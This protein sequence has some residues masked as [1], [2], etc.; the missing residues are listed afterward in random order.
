MR[1]HFGSNHR[2]VPLSDAKCNLD[3]GV[4]LP[5]KYSSDY[6]YKRDF[7]FKNPNF[8]DDI[9]FDQRDDY[10]MM[11]DCFPKVEILDACKAREKT[12]IICG[13][14]VEHFL[15]G[16]MLSS[17]L[18]E[19]MT[20]GGLASKCAMGIRTGY[21]GWDELYRFL[22]E[23]CENSDATRFD[24]SISPKLLKYVYLCRE[25]LTVFTGNQRNMFWWYFNNLVRRRS[26]LSHGSVFNVFGGNG[27]GQYNTS[28]DNTIAHLLCLAYAHVRMGNKYQDF[29]ECKQVVYGDDYIGQAMPSIFWK[30][31]VETGIC[32]KKTPVM[33]KDSCDF[34]SSTFASTPYGIA[35]SPKTDK[36]LFSVFTCENRKW[37]SFKQEKLY[38]LWLNYYFTSYRHVFE[39]IMEDCGL[40]FNSFDA[41]DFHFG[42]M[43]GF[44]EHIVKMLPQ[45]KV[46]ITAKSVSVNKR[47]RT[48]RNKKNRQKR[49][50]ALQSLMA[51]PGAPAT[52]AATLESPLDSGKLTAVDTPRTRQQLTKLVA[53]SC[54][55]CDPNAVAWY[56]KYLDP[57]GS[58]ESGRVIG[59]CGKIPDGLVKFSVDAE[60]RVI[61]DERVPEADPSA[62]A[63]SGALWSL[64]IFSFPMYRTAY[65][66][67]CNNQNKEF[68]TDDDLA[69]CVALNSLPDWRVVVDNGQWVPFGS[70]GSGWFFRIRQL[71]PTYDLPDPT[72]GDVRTVTDYRITYKSLSCRFNAPDL[73]DQGWWIGGHYALS[74]SQIQAETLDGTDL[75]SGLSMML[76]ST[77]G[78]NSIWSVQWPRLSNALQGALSGTVSGVGSNGAFLTGTLNEGSIHIN[79]PDYAGSDPFAEAGST[80]TISGPVTS[81]STVVI[82][83]TSGPGMGNTYTIP[84]TG[85]AVP[86]SIVRPPTITEDGR[87]TTTALNVNRIDM[88]PTTSAQI[89]ANNPEIENFM[90]RYSGGA[91][92]VHSK[93]RNPVFELT[94]ANQFG[95]VH[96]MTPGYAPE[97]QDSAP[98]GIRDSIDNNLSSAVAVFRSISTSASMQVI[99]YQG[100]E[101]VTA[102]NTPFGQFGHVGLQKHPPIL[103]MADDLAVRLT[104]VYEEEDNTAAVVAACAANALGNLMHSEATQSAIQAIGNGAV[105]AVTNGLGNVVSKLPSV[106]ARIPSVFSRLGARLRSRRNR[107]Q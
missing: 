37:R 87:L 93:M 50:G 55:D 57:V 36:G 17:S 77:G 91:Y 101:G 18:N 85:T 46:N 1:V 72:E 44:K 33:Y 70:E 15:V 6:V 80:I 12:R 86:G 76:I 65:I 30:Y 23:L 40:E 24:K 25:R 69:L 21:R 67:A 73:L 68:G 10:S 49:S 105:Q 27:S 35:N 79:D 62:L 103:D 89:A 61:F 82:A 100:W 47:N 29:V 98:N 54:L 4:G 97:V 11:W 51:E 26:H 92:L 14:P 84:F 2:V 5:Y 74:P 34:L 42:W 107:K 102:R 96:F 39:E 95:I 71:S 81:T 104:G 31:F 28:T 9:N 94:R 106:L 13:A 3:G 52:V 53:K 43:G 64:Y 45:D 75:V 99:V 88:L 90:C 56:F 58:T 8:I 66:A 19:A 63:L 60:I 83:V 22:P 16:A 32:I 41:Y 20:R 78:A 7:L 48:R 59:E 38:S